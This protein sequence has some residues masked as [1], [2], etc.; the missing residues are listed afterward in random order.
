MC[1]TLW[2]RNYTSTDRYYG[3]SAIVDTILLVLT[4]SY[5][6]VENNLLDLI[7]AF[8]TKRQTAIVYYVLSDGV[9]E[10]VAL[11]VYRY[12]YCSLTCSA[13]VSAVMLLHFALY[14]VCVCVCVSKV[15][16]MGLD[17]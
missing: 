9:E 1:V 3:I 11:P 17:N 13:R 7:P 16:C 14:L 12:H 8:C 5:C 6:A 2:R 15:T 10:L 4:G